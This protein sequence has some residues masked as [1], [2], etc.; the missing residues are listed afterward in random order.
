M[1]GYFLSPIICGPDHSFWKQLE[2][3]D[4]DEV[5]EDYEQQSFKRAKFN[6]APRPAPQ[7]YTGYR[8][9]TYELEDPDWCKTHK[10][11]S[12][13]MAATNPSL[14]SSSSVWVSFLALTSM[15]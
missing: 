7:R 8:D 11:V 15:M 5:V 2:V 6:P 9:R 4:I 13:A 10:S 3:P 1:R 12:P 14:T